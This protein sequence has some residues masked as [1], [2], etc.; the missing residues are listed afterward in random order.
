MIGD[1]GWTVGS[2]V[3]GAGARRAGRCGRH[4]SRRRSGRSGPGSRADATKP[5][6]EADLRRIHRAALDVLERIGVGN[7]IPSCIEA[8]TAVAP[9]RTARGGSASRA[10]WS[11]TRWP[12]PP[13][14]S[15]SSA[16]TRGTTWSRGEQASTSARPGRRSTWSTR[17]PAPTASWC[18]A[19]STMPARIVDALEH[20]HFFQRPLVPRDMTSSL[21]LDVNTLYACLAGTTKHIGTSFVRPE[22]ARA[23]LQMLHRLAGGEA[24]WRA[25]PF[26][27]LSCCFVVP[28]L[29][30]AEDACRVLEAA[31]AGRHAGAAALGRP[32]RRHQ[33]AALAGAVVQA[34]AECLAGLVYVNA[35]MP[36]APAIF[37]PGRSSPTCGPGPCR[38]A[39]A[40]RP[41]SSAACAQM[42]QFYD[43]PRASRPA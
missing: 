5:L 15:R 27:S 16:A 22:H 7:P 24:A 37:G 43:L 14:D 13:A 39:A 25:R 36:G 1:G 17:R 28:P 18:C 42:G 31:V 35:I 40:S 30:L 26:V 9:R 11:R 20:I 4:R 10:R 34:V 23:A 29:K 33:P 41:C 38:A 3:G 2:A 6:A 21:E 8:C 19:T 32:G 12:A